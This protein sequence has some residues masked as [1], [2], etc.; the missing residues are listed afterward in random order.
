VN[1]KLQKRL[2]SLPV[3]YRDAKVE[4]VDFENRIVTFS[5]SSEA[6][7]ERWYGIEILDHSPSS[8]DKSRL[9]QGIPGL[10]NHDRNLQ[11][12]RIEDFGVKDK[13]LYVTQ[14]FGN[15][16]FAQEKLVDARDKILVDASIGYI[17]HDYQ[18]TEG[19]NG[20]PDTVRWTNWTPVEA[21]LVTVPADI[22]VGIGR[23]LED[24]G[25]P[26]FP[27]RCLNERD[28]DE[29]DDDDDCGCE[30]AACA[31]GNHS[32][33][34]TEDCDY[35]DG[36]RGANEVSKPAQAAT[37]ER[38]N[39][40]QLKAAKEEAARAERER[41]SEINALQRE[42]GDHF[43]RE[44]AE[45]AIN[46]GVTVDS[47]RAEIL[48]TQREASKV[49]EVRSAAPAT[50]PAIEVVRDVADKRDKGIVV[51]RSLRALAASRGDFGR[52]E[53]FARE[54]LKDELV[55]RSFA[56]A[57]SSAADGGYALQGSYSAEIIELLR[58]RAVVRS[59]NPA[60][61]PLDGTYTQNRLIGGASG[62]YIGENQDITATKG[63]FGQLKL[64]AKKLAALV[65]ISND[66]L[67]RSGGESADA[68]VRDDLMISLAN[69][70][71][72]SFIRSQG[73]QYSP[74]GLRYWALP[75]NVITATNVTG[76]TGGALVQ[77]VQAD[78]GKL[79]LA[80]RKA[81]VRFLRPGIIMSVSTEYFLE[82][83]LNGL[84]YPVF[85]EEMAQGKFMGYP[86]RV[87]TQ[88]PETLTVNGVANSTELYFADFADVTIGDAPQIG[89]E[90]STEASYVDPGTGQLVSAFSQD[91]TVMR[92]LIE[93]DLGMRHQ[94]SI[95]VL[96]GVAYYNQASA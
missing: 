60:T 78:I 34:T 33:C 36:N 13:K 65:P 21:S 7:V 12:G 57:A 38:M 43:T 25:G 85:R 16:P 81:N 59:L 29:G 83:L 8:I 92:V 27:V 28:A 18:F 95:A 71:D 86:Y 82:N 54:V 2:E 66:L 47:V 69:T 88:I 55:A 73:S 87:T 40:E 96:N 20:K 6:P 14:R 67:R 90:F 74:K 11:T 51:A 24:R 50:Q 72:V 42:H 5:V 10:F 3:Q 58:P 4:S 23:S 94:E 62:G 45:K 63:K 48:K 35:G 37:E 9:N 19:K 26:R 52:A 56:A 1:K 93:H 89:I 32:D 22:T 46:N 30:C 41:V 91:Q 70:E 39:E 77:A 68:A 53:K 64:S 31:D 15:S 49:A 76:L 79:K 84:G 75:A 44:A 61:V 80:L 17:P